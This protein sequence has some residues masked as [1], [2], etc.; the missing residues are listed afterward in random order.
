M[1]ARDAAREDVARDAEPPQ[2]GP[3]DPRDYSRRT[4]LANERTYLAWWRT[5]LTTLTVAL[6]AARVV[7]E[8]SNVKTT[9]PYV[10]IGVAFAVLGVVCIAAGEYRRNAVDRAV[11]R[12]EFANL[13]RALS[14][15]ITLSGII[16]GLLVIA[17]ILLDA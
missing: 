2:L 13:N 14:V 5:G 1:S 8:L 17:V 9:W 4:L 3:P 6:A 10:V 7:P 12:G 15:G 16:L 11:R